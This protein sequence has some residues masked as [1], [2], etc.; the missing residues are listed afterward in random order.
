[1][2]LLILGA[3]SDVAWA[4]AKIFAQKEKVNL[5]LA[6]RNLEILE[7]K[8]RDIQIRFAVSATAMTFDVL[9]VSS[10]KSFYDKLA[11]KPD[12]VVLACGYLGD[13]VQAQK[14]FAEARRII[15]TNYTGAVSILEI[16]AADFET[17]NTGTIVAIGSVA[18]ERGRK[19]NYFY[20]SAK[21][22]L[23]IY[24]SGLRNRLYDSGVKVITVLPGFIRT[25][26]TANMML[27][28][29]LTAEPETVAADIYQAFTASKNRLYTKWFWRWIIMLIKAIPES[30]FK[31]M[32][33]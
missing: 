15:D 18:G 17:R 29:F 11:P 9:D 14:N 24:L 13:Q 12:V 23:A 32:N 4:V 6:S 2:N 16:I 1:M 30:L 20:G 21:G 19:S 26:M 22:A 28:G 7:K 3:N 10:H 33:I 5:L 25:K 27:P 31:R 8:V